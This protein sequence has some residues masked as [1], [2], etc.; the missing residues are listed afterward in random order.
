VHIALPEIES[1]VYSCYG[2]AVSILFLCN[3]TPL[4]PSPPSFRCR[5]VFAVPMSGKS[6]SR[7]K[8]RKQE[9]SAAKLT[10]GPSVPLAPLIAR[11]LEQF[12]VAGETMGGHMTGNGSCA[13]E[14]AKNALIRGELQA[15]KSVHAQS[16]QT[17]RFCFTCLMTVV[18]E[19]GQ[20]A[21]M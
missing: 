6:Q 10:L 8:A 2:V 16:T 9:Q 14:R 17:C 5:S 12:S 3:A 13:Q 15:T 7:R 19:C 21:Y 20:N 18:S 4:P 11:A 1:V